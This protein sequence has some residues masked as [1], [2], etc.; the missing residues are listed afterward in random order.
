MIGMHNLYVDC[1]KRL[2][3]IHS[4]IIFFYHFLKNGVTSSCMVS[5]I[6]KSGKYVLEASAGH[7]ILG[8][9]SIYVRKII[10][11]KFF[12]PFTKNVTV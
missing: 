5:C 9:K 7:V 3:A 1:T 4:E 11:D 6:A 10:F 12:P 2:K 8:W